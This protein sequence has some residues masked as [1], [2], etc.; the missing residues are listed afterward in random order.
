MPEGPWC[1]GLVVMLTSG[2]SSIYLPRF[3]MV[4]QGVT[5]AYEVSQNNGA[6]EW[7]VSSVDAYYWPEWGN[8]LLYTACLVKTGEPGFY[9]LRG[10]RGRHSYSP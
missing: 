6:Y 7:A 1:Q 8:M 10:G 3:Y 2:G 5:P 9:E 4:W